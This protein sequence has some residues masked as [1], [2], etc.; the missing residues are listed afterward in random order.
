MTT[1]ADDYERDVQPV[2]AALAAAG[3]QTRDFGHF[4]NRIVP[5]VIEPVHF[6]AAR[7]MPVLLEWLPCVSNE[8][9]REAMVRHLAV[10]TGGSQP[11][12]TLIQEYRRP[13]SANYK[14]VVANSLAFACARQ[15]FAAITELAADSSPGIGRQPLIE[16]LWRVKTPAADQTMLD[17]LA[18][19]DTA[20]AAMSALR[21]RLGNADA[22]PHITPLLSHAD[23]RVS[24][25]ARQHLQRIDKR[26]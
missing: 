1:P 9:V 11:A 23:Q 4:V 25:A 14:W 21:R 24:R 6:D 19:P 20:L 12:D 22:R 2:K 18:C 26:A 8:R 3:I 5:G 7:A 10:K 17:A 13:G 16:M 15:H